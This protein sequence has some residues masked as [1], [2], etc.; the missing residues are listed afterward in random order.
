MYSSHEG[1]TFT[2]QA[3]VDVSQLIP[4]LLKIG[5]FTCDPLPTFSIRHVPL[6]LSTLYA[7]HS[8]TSLSRHIRTAPC[9]SDMAQNILFYSVLA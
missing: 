7:L 3:C 9:E 2:V 1:F 8:T 6:F 5:P 4:Q